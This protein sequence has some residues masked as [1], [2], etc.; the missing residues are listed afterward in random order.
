VESGIAPIVLG[1]LAD[2]VPNVR[3]N[4]ALAAAALAP[5]A[6]TESRESRFRA[7]LAKLADGDKDADVRHFAGVALRRLDA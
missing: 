5:V 2:P 4:A 7:G 1:L 3:F 6:P